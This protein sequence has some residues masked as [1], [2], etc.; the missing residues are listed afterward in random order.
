MCILK[1]VEN[2]SVKSIGDQILQFSLMPNDT[3]I[4]KCIHLL[5]MASGKLEIPKITLEYFSD[6]KEKIILDLTDSSISNDLPKSILAHCVDNVD[7]LAR[8]RIV[9]N[10]TA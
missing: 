10:Q 8:I 9:P 2:D 3:D 6:P 5:P 4:K 1:V 7:A